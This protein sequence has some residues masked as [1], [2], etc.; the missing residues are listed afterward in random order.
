MRTHYI[1]WDVI[2]SQYVCKRR[3][4]SLWRVVVGRFIVVGALVVQVTSRAS[5]FLRVVRHGQSFRGDGH[6]VHLYVRMMHDSFLYKVKWKSSCF[7]IE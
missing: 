3:V 6:V 5:Q 4:H 7:F 2:G 1:K